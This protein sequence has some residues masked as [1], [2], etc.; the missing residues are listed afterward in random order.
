ME[1]EIFNAKWDFF[2]N[3]Y[4]FHIEIYIAFTYYHICSLWYPNDVLKEDDTNPILKS[5]I[6]KIRRVEKDGF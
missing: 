1:V 4:V 5:R 6:V 3:N 2:Q